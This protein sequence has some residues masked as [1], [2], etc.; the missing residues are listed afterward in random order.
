VVHTRLG[1]ILQQTGDPI[2]AR[3][4][5]GRA[6]HA[7]HAIG[8]VEISHLA[9]CGLAQLA[10]EAGEP[11]RALMLVSVAVALAQGTG[12]QASLPVQARLEQ[13]RAA[14]AQ[15]LSAEVQV[16]A[17]ATGQTLSLEQVIAETLAHAGA[18]DQQV[19]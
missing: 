16:A 14:A 8:H 4:H 15:A 2:A 19:D 13:V 10:T 7:L 3:T 11:A 6:L 5:Y 17:W 18:A 9:L 12:V 1:G